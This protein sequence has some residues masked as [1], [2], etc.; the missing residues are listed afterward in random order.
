MAGRV[1]QPEQ[2]PARLPADLA[3][4]LGADRLMGRAA[5]DMLQTVRREVRSVLR[6]ARGDRFQAMRTG[7]SRLRTDGWISGRDV[8]R[9][10]TLVEIIEL[11]ADRPRFPRDAVDKIRETHQAI[12]ADS[13]SSAAALAIGS[14][15]NNLV[16]PT[17]PIGD[18]DDGV[19]YRVAQGHVE[20]GA[21]VITG[22]MIGAGV[23][24]EVGGLVG[25]GLGALIGG[26]VG[27]V[28]GECEIST[29]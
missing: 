20:G 27:A 13:R 17:E 9:L 2:V 7:L 11:T 4:G 14:L 21:A 1:A 12:V 8:D 28:A 3:A 19:A 26:V 6:E 25:A 18:A 16:T 10:R 15:V 24:G 5:G 23:G 29:G 22:A